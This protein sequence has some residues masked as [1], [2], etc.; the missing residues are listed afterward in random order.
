MGRGRAGAGRSQAAGAGVADVL[1]LA[2]TLVVC[3]VLGRLVDRS[4]LGRPGVGWI[5]AFGRGLMLGFGTVGVLSMLLDMLRLPV[6]L[7]SLGLALG[8]TAL[9]LLLL[10]RGTARQATPRTVWPAGG[11][12][13]TAL[14]VMA[15]ITLV[16]LALVVRS[17]WLRPTFQFDA[18]TR[19]MFKTKALFE[20]GT[21]RGAVSTDP[22]F[23]FTHQQY[24][25][26]VAHV[27]ALPA[28]VSGVWEDRIT[29]AI[30]PWYAV[31][32]AAVAY[33]AV[34]RRAGALI[35]CFAATWV[36]TLPL[37]A[38]LAG[39][40]PGAG[41][42]S[43]LADIPL[44]LFVLG[45]GLAAHDLVQGERPRAGL[46]LGLLLGFGALTKNEGLPFVVALTLA[47]LVCRRRL[48][49]RAALAPVGL[50]LLLYVGLWGWLSSS[51]PA[52]DENYW[53]RMHGDALRQGL[54]RIPLIATAFALH[55]ADMRQWNIT[56]VA[57]AVLFA[58]GW[59]SLRRLP[60]LK[61]VLI[62][63]ILQLGAYAF[64]YLIT[65]WSSPRAE[66][67]MS[68]DDPLEVLFV[69]TL[70]RLLLHVAPLAIVGGILAS[71]LG[72]PAADPPGTPAHSG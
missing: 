60:G 36:A 67:V 52:L 7:V 38:Y 37:I 46:E 71:P 66:A 41:A 65:G 2:L 33:G 11:L 56:W 45:A 15:A 69:L 49:W 30:Y 24:P 68:G 48:P 51:F 53:G 58:V 18:V 54:E 26:L 55:M 8:L 4:L 59:P 31:A 29:S 23:W 28:Y 42:F 64:A 39:P 61:L 20:D 9:V 44:A 27:A 43:A 32:I 21:L 70:G 6:G 25:P 5:E 19:W 72:R 62:A 14:G 50:A 1:E 10:G 3:L 63:V 12:E 35:G 13:W 47:L 40:P 17:G 22:G 16:S 57:V 34:A